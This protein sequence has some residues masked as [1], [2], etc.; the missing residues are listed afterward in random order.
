MK[1]A[2]LAATVLYT[3]RGLCAAEPVD[4]TAQIKPILKTRC[5]SCHGALKQEAGLRLDTGNLL[6]KG[7]ESGSPVRVSQPDESLLLQRVSDPDLSGR[8][9]PEGK[10]LSQLQIDLLRK[11]I[12]AGAV[13]P[14]DENPDADPRDHWAFNSPQRNVP[15]QI[16]SDPWVRNP[17]DAWI[18]SRLAEQGLSPL[19]P[20]K[21]HLLLRRVSLDLIGLPPTRGELHAFLNDDSP[22]A[23]EKVVNRLLDSRHYGERWGRH[24]M[25]VWRYSD[26]Y[27]RRNVNDVRNSYPHIWRWRDWIINSLNEDKG[28]DQMVREMLA[29]DELYPADDERIPALGFIVRNWF[30]LNYDTWKQDL[31]EHTGKAFLGLRMNCAHCHD[32]KYDPISQQEYFQFRAFFEPLEF[33]H[34]RVAGGPELKKYLRYRPGSGGSLRPIEAGLPRVYD[35]YPD[36]KTYM[37]R[38]GDTRDRL[39]RDPVTPA[40]PAILGGDSLKIEP[41]K[42]PLTAWYPGLKAFAIKADR[43]AVQSE[44]ARARSDQATAQ[45]ALHAMAAPL[46]AATANLE[47]AAQQAEA[48][49][50]PEDAGRDLR[51][52][53]AYWRFEGADDEAFFADSSGRAN[54]VRLASGSD[55]EVAKAV[56]PKSG[57]FGR[58]LVPEPEKNQQAAEFS[59]RG[60]FSHLTAQGTAGFFASRFSFECLIRSRAARRNFNR[61]IADYPG[62]WM[63]LLRG[64][65]EQQSELRVRYFNADGA[66]RD[67]ATGGV[68]HPEM[69]RVQSHSQPILLQTGRDYYICLVMGEKQVRIL[70]ADLTAGTP[71]SSFEFPRSPAGADDGK[72]AADFSELYRPDPSTPLNL[73][74]SDGTGQF[75]GLL[76]EVRYSSLPLSETQIAA[77]VGQ[78]GNADVRKAMS[79]LHA[80][81]RR[82]TLLEKSC[83]AADAAVAAARSRLAAIET[84]VRADK[85]RYARVASDDE[86]ASLIHAAAV[87]EHKSGLAA[88][89]SKLLAGERTLLE[90]QQADTPDAKIRQQA[91]AAIAAAQ[92]QTMVLEKRQISSDAD[93]AAAG[94]QYP[95][96]STGRRAALAHWITRPDNPLTARVAVNHIWMRHFGRP[97]VESVFDFGRGG[98]APTFP[99]LLDWLAVELMQ[100]AHP[101]ADAKTPPAAWSMKHIHR[102]IV[103]SNAYRISSRPGPEHAGLQADP[104]NLLF[105]RFEQRRLE[106]EIIRDSLLHVSGQ[107]DSTLGGHDLAPTLE[108]TSRRRSLYFSVYPEGGGMMSFLTL[109]DAP[110]PCDCYRRTESLVPQ[111]ALGMSN[112][113]LALN[114]GRLLTERLSDSARTS[115]GEFVVAAYETVLTRG[116]TA[117]ESDAC[118]AFLQNQRELFTAVEFK[119]RPDTSQERVP[120]STDPVQRARESLV[121]VLLNHHEFVTVH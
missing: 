32:H 3:V 90:Q 51:H 59:D 76:D 112:S 113:R 50:R 7:G 69:P 70:V 79:D 115:D 106:A 75:V 64:I 6:R 109:F 12:T 98:K 60:K 121:R 23:Y 24:W 35:Q 110:D 72:S 56:I 14:A 66:L 36:E 19:P 78:V 100:P 108:A 43:D 17:I 71:L 38:L 118:Y 18:A 30:S 48:A 52:V 85:A 81:G 49:A 33:R 89:R 67:A 82:R 80:V 11:W 40:G 73:G 20:A 57:S 54:T 77:T 91:E 105:W 103:T 1:T 55:F 25:D 8:M 65:D 31:V 16:H 13:S 37:Y 74:N 95:R 4:Y 114:L 119:P 117:E 42:L 92:K 99:E 111:Q 10:P 15:E 83:E 84:R 101:E 94:P 88:A 87:S 29:A 116:P 47:Q 63:L 41:I 27:G 45:T 44:L 86:I 5:L 107:L 53:I 34:D 21:K 39:D 68:D 61:I 46:A 97:L 28:Y 102:L 26:W 120:A 58:F 2:L 9:P 93:Y 22:G 96:T 62:C 104:D